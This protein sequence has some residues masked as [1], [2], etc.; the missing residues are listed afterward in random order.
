MTSK[1]HV[2]QSPP[3]FTCVVTNIEHIRVNL[4]V[5][6]VADFTLLVIMLVGLL[7]LCPHRN[8]MLSLAHL[9]WKQ[10]GVDRSPYDALNPFSCFPILSVSFGFSLPLLQESRQR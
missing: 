6:L 8:N 9:L 4:A 3:L 1:L 10:V 7:R 5:L 2:T